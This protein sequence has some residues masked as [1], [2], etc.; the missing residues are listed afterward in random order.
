M[1]KDETISVLENG[2][3]TEKKWNIVKLKIN[4]KF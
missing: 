3:L 4:K 2:N 1:S